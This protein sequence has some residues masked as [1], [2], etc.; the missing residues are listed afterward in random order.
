[1][2]SEKIV[3]AH[4]LRLFVWEVLKINSNLETVN[5]LVPIVPLEDEP[6][7]AD[8]GKPY[9]IYGYA[10]MDARKSDLNRRGVL[11][12]R[13]VAPTTAELTSISNILASV[14]EDRDRATEAVN[15]WSSTMPALIGIRFTE[16]RV[17]FV[18][19]GEPAESEGGPVNTV[20]NISYEYITDLQIT[21]PGVARGGLW[22]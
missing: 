18:E 7:L 19:R 6:V 1:M 12:L 2:I 8:T 20:V 16:T 10:E 14:F 5:D 21:L 9:I 13:I 15:R 3:P 17:T 22:T 4:V 11:S